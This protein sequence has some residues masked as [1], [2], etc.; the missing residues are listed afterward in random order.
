MKIFLVYVIWYDIIS[1]LCI[2]ERFNMRLPAR[3][4]FALFLL[5]F[6]SNRLPGDTVL[7]DDRVDSQQK[8]EIRYNVPDG[9][10]ITG[11]GFRA[12]Y[13]NITTMYVRHH[14]L[15]A[16]GRLA[17]ETDVWLGSEPNHACEARIDLPEGWVAVG[18]GAAGEPEWDVTLLRIW[19]RKLEQDGTLGEGK[20]FNHGF[21]PERE[22]E[23]DVLLSEG[24]RVLTG[25]GL[26]FASNDIGGIYARSQRIV[27]LDD[28]VRRQLQSITTRAWAVD[29]SAVKDINRLA[30]DLRKY[31]ASRVDLDF[32]GG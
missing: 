7:F 20:I 22:P 14:R 5:G 18:F 11:L 16:D 9:C 13:D 28:N 6:V 30:S 4:V 26:R 23:R 3:I 17:E 21:K 32:R 31:G 2:F 27:R 25:A 10:V 24:D 12:H 1:T 19:A 8:T 15:T 29:V